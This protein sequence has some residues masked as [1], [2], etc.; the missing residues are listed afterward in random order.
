EEVE[1]I[2][3]ESGWT[4]RLKEGT[5]DVDLKGGKD[6]F[7][8]EHQSITVTRDGK[9]TVRVLLND[10]PPKKAGPVHQNLPEKHAKRRSYMLE[11]SGRRTHVVIPKLQYDGSHPITFEATV[12]S[13]HR[14]SIIANFSGAGLGLDVADGYVSFH[15]N[16]GRTTDNGYV[17]VKS[18]ISVGRDKPVHIAGVLDGNKLRLFVD[19]KVQGSETIGKFNKS[20]FPFMIGADPGGQGEPTQFLNGFIDEVRV[21]KTAR[22]DKDFAPPSQFEADKRTLLL[23][24]FD[25]GEEDVAHDASDNALHARIHG[26]KWVP[27]KTPSGIVDSEPVDDDTPTPTPREVEGNE[28]SA[29]WNEFGVT[30]APVSP[31]T[32][33]VLEWIGLH[34]RPIKREGFRGK[35]VFAKYAGGLAVTFVRTHGPAE[36]AGIHDV[37]IVVTLRGLGV[38]SLKELD[39]AIQDAVRNDAVSLQFEVLRGGETVDVNVPIV[40]RELALDGE[41]IKRLEL[42]AEQRKARPRT[43]DHPQPAGVQPTQPR[44]SAQ[45]EGTK[46]RCEVGSLDLEEMRVRSIA[47]DG[48]QVRRGDLLVE[49]SG[50]SIART[51]S[52]QKI[53]LSIAESRL[54][55]S[56]LDRDRIVTAAEGKQ[57]EAKTVVSAAE[58]ALAAYLDGDRAVDVK[59]LEAAVKIAELTL[60]RAERPR[61]VAGQEK[62]EQVDQ[63]EVEKAEIA[64]DVAKLRLDV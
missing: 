23:Y 12:M 16:D 60:K 27:T 56:R 22:Y 6:K 11:F 53:K 57:A 17:R 47:P 19:G 37:D 51:V 54:L 49:F 40:L 5:Y 36:K 9:V 2:N 39:S 24:R 20:E 8:L 50:D 32:A 7:K 21:S 38:V 63:A 1:I 3:A 15:V 26:A 4:I 42:L 45:V 46:I 64:L 18:S 62:I 44:A 10:T 28:D 14:G 48:K 58:V 59:A 29:L 43:Q 55:Q 25:E 61:A 33:K 35:N 31:L 30:P 34:L 52:E 13:L 41:R